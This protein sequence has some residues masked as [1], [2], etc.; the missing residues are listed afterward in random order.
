MKKEWAIITFILILFSLIP[1]CSKDSDIQDMTEGLNGTSW[2]LEGYVNTES[3]ELTL[4]KFADCKD[5]NIITF[6]SDSTAKGITLFNHIWVNLNSKPLIGIATLVDPEDENL[7]QNASATKSYS[8][9]N[10]ELTINGEKNHI[11]FKRV[12]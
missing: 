12:K 5:C 4:P 8:V 3:G 9:N 10:K 7:S 1:S 2:K 6:D 11:V